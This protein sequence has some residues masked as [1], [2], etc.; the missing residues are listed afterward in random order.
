M[1]PAQLVSLGKI[2][3]SIKDGMSKAEDWFAAEESAPAKDAPTAAKKGLRA[4]LGVVEKNP[5][6]DSANAAEATTDAP[7]AE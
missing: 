5:Q 3:N 2:Y 6:D 1:K 7:N 4:A